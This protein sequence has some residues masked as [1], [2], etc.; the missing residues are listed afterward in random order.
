MVLL[1]SSRVLI[2]DNYLCSPKYRWW[3]GEDRMYQVLSLLIEGGL[4]KHL[5]NLMFPY[6]HFFES[7]RQSFERSFNTGDQLESM[8]P[9]SFFYITA[10]VLALFFLAL[11]IF[12]WETRVCVRRR[13][14]GKNNKSADVLTRGKGQAF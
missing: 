14:R 5:F 7:D 6:H 13:G 3:R 2:H 10:L 8:S 11:A 4:D 12:M 9:E 1:L